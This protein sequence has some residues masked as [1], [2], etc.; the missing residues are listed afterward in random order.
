VFGSG[1]Q[2]LVR[3]EA[4]TGRVTRTYLPHVADVR[5]DVVPVA[6]G[7]LVHRGDD[8][9]TWL[10]PDGRPVRAVPAL[11]RRGPMLPGPDPDQVWLMSGPNPNAP[12]ML[13]GLD[14]RVARGASASPPRCPP[15]PPRT[16]AGTRCSSRS[17][18]STGPGLAGCAG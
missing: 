10:V 7:V 14:G 8:G 11:E 3:V 17:K 2:E 5:P 13:V 1:R 15:T 4:A 6:G 12:M 18:A 9:R 16:G